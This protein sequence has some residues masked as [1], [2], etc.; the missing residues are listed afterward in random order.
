MRVVHGLVCA[1]AVAL[2][3]PTVIAQD[4][5]EKDRV[6][7]GGG[8][9]AAGWTARIDAAAVTKG[10]KIEDSKF[11]Q[12]GQDFVLN[13]GPAATYWNPR[14]VAKGD[15]TVKATIKNLKSN[16]GHPHSAGIF[17]GGQNMDDETK[18]AYTYC[19]VY[20]NGGAL[21]RQFTGV[22]KPLTIFGG[23][24]PANVLPAV[25]PEGPDGATNEIAWTVK[26]GVATCSVNG[27]AIATVEA[28]KMP[29]TDGIY[30][31][32]VTHNVDLTVTGFGVSK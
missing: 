17:I 3:A 32:R 12:Q 5:G 29:T 18:Q 25:K 16:A 15:Y 26:G 24:R 28:G 30:G 22:G 1:V 8:I 14:N 19:V 9:K 23:N 11:V 20:T 2:V 13:I 4:A 6:V 7:A 31:I 10:A 21:V 27:T